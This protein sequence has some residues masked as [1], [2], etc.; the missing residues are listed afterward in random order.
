[1]HI[2]LSHNAADDLRQLK[3]ADPR[4]AAA[5]LVALEQIESDPNVI[6]KLTTHGNSM[7]GTSS[8]NVKPWESMK[9]YGNLW[10]FRILDT[11]ATSYA[12]G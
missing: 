4:A 9:P 7:I 5:V 2:D 3:V 1:M 6:D 10:R 12:H 11:P 8:L